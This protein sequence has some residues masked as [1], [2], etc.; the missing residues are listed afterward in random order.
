MIMSFRNVFMSMSL[1]ALP[2]VDDD[3]VELSLL[4]E[5]F[6]GGKTAMALSFPRF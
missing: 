2:A 4:V 5:L 1:I 3:E 6:T